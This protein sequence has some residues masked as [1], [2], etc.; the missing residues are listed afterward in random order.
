MT[1][2]TFVCDEQFPCP[3]R[4]FSPASDRAK[5]PLFEAIR[6][7]VHTHATILTANSRFTRL[8]LPRGIQNKKLCYHEKHST[9][10]ML[11]WCTL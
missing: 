9:S 3:S 11:S 1:V 4:C 2:H 5:C 8:W 6:A 10:V 7:T